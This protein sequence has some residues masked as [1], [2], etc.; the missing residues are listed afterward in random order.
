MAMGWWK[1]SDIKAAFAEYEATKARDPDDPTQHFHI[2]MA[3]QMAGQ[4]EKAEVKYEYFVEQ[5][6]KL[7]GGFDR[8]LAH[9]TEIFRTMK[10]QGGDP[11]QDRATYNAERMIKVMNE[12]KLEKEKKAKRCTIS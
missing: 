8:A 3:M 4:S 10:A 5:S 7:H 1:V 9:Y 6:C 11:L 12:V 2:G